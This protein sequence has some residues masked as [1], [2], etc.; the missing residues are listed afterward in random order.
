MLPAVLELLAAAEKIFKQ[1]GVEFYLVG[2]LA[3]D[4]HLAANPAF[5]PQRKTKDIDIAILISDEDQF[6]AIKEAMVNSGDFSAHETETVKLI[7]KQSIEIDLLPFGGIENEQRE[8]LLHKPR[9]FVMDVPG[10][11]EA[12]IDIEEF[13]LE[14]NVK[15]K[16]CSLEAIILLKI[17]AND[18]NPGRTKDITDIE[19]IISVYFDLNDEKIY[20]ERGDVLDLYDTNDNDYLKLVSA[21]IIGRHIGNLLTN[22]VDLHRRVI[23]ILRRKNSIPYRYAIEEGM[24]DTIITI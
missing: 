6:Y 5:M 13:K 4:I 1:F 3:R 2:A 14:N 24:I 8:A 12:Y 23:A 21:R 19:H 22:S 18:N 10:F 16:V 15:L 17:I 20:Q 7:Y 9:L 11:L